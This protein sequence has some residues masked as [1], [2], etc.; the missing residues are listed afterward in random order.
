MWVY[1]YA[2]CIPLPTCMFTRVCVHAHVFIVCPHVSSVGLGGTPAVPD[3]R[4]PPPLP[5][6]WPLLCSAL[7]EVRV[8]VQDHGPAQ[9]ALTGRPWAST[10]G[11]HLPVVSEMHCGLC[12]SCFLP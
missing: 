8:W 10:P 4:E 1:M 11:G 12:S 9:G 5:W 3:C 7:R 6:P 2:N